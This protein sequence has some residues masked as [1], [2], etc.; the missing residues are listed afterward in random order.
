MAAI[1]PLGPVSAVQ[2]GAAPMASAATGTGGAVVAG[3]GTDDGQDQRTTDALFKLGGDIL[4]PKIKA[5]ADRQFFSGV[6]RAASGEAL[7]EIIKDQPWYTQIFGP[8]SAA[9][10]ARAYSTQAKV[11]E[12]GAEMEKQMPNLAKYGPEAVVKAAQEAMSGLRTG[13]E[14]ADGAIQMAFVD[15]LQ[16]LLKRHAKESYIYQQKEAS[17]AQVKSWGTLFDG[18]QQRAL[19]AGNPEGGVTAE[20]MEAETDRVLMALQPFADQSPESYEKNVGHAL[21]GAAAAG[22]F[23]VIDALKKNGI[24][25]ALPPDMQAQLKPIFARGARD[26][27]NKA[28]PKYAYD[29]AMITNDTAQDPRKAAARVQA[30]SEEVSRREGIPLEYGS[31]FPPESVDNMVGGILRAQAAQAGKEHKQ[32]AEE[33]RQ[34]QLSFA[35][36]LMTQP[37]SLGKNV[38]MGTIPASVAEEAAEAAWM[39]NADPKARAALLNARGAGTYTTIKE[40]LAA[41]SP[42]ATDKDTLG[43]QHNAALYHNMNDETRGAYYSA[44][45]QLFFDRYNA[46][47][48]AGVPPE[49]AFAS[50]RIA[51]PMAK[52]VIPEKDKSAVGKAI[53]S[54]VENR[55]ENMLGWNIVDDNSLRIIEAS[56]ARNYNANASLHGT[57]ASVQRSLTMALN[58]GLEIVG[59]HAVI[60]TSRGQAPLVGIMAKGAGNMGAKETASAFESVLSE[61][62]AAAGGSLDSYVLYRMPDVKGEARYLI[63]TIDKEGK[64]TTQSLS[65]QELRGRN[66]EQR[67]LEASPDAK[68]FIGYGRKRTKE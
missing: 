32:T 37:G 17:A 68:P 43:V 63:E 62:V 35:S 49:Q 19:A 22:N 12:F 11:A 41:M 55:M 23:H 33:I 45:E 10:G 13:D 7:E 9:M 38:A 28:M 56:V 15:Q 20:D 51:Q 57:T 40:S 64:L 67:K 39:S 27:L 2:I 16:P 4:A 52:D 18:Y 50:A 29:L 47:V 21:Q 14:L 42:Y 66:K 24:I 26:A 59:K 8:S 54:E 46:S 34:A 48:Y 60:G 6:Q 53:R 3:R 5:E 25:D 65:S 36:T 1:E 31:I 44:Q 58:D 61:K 30:F